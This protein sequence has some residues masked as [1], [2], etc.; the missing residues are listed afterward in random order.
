MSKERFKV[1]A[2]VHLV[3]KNEYNEY[4]LLRRKHTGYNDGNYSLVGGHLE[5]D[6]TLR[7]ALI[8][9]VFEEIG[10]V[11]HKNQLRLLHII[12]RKRENIKDEDRM[13]FFFEAD[14]YEG[15]ITN[16]ETFKC[17]H[18]DWFSKKKLPENIANYIRH[19]ILSYESNSYSEFGW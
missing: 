18:L 1:I 6:E 3:L 13:D 14:G 15:N 5:K 19:F 7:E 10:V 2:T 12:H 4:L 8:R 16:R 11:I 17:D 9:E